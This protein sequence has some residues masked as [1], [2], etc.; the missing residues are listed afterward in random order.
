MHTITNQHDRKTDCTYFTV[1]ASV[2]SQRAAESRWGR[3][4]EKIE[5]NKVLL[6]EGGSLTKEKYRTV[7]HIDKR[8]C[9]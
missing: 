4:Y 8:D 6:E 1:Y 2:A 3:W 5:S 7:L 9:Y